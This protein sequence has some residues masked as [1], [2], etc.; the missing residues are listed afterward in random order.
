MTKIECIL[1]LTV[2]AGI[3]IRALAVFLRDVTR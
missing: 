2:C 1:L 3:M